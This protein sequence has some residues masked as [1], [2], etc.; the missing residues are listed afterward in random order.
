M[1]KHMLPLSNKF[2]YPKQLYNPLR[3]EGGTHW[4]G[5]RTDAERPKVKRA[6]YGN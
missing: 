1:R 4:T 3:K 2:R 6:R 5:G